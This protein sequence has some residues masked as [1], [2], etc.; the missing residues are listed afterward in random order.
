MTVL[1]QLEAEL[2]AKVPEV[3]LLEAVP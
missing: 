1:T 3:E 2:R